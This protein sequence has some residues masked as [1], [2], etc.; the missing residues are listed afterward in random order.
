MITIEN[1]SYF[2][3]SRLCRKTDS[4]IGEPGYRP[5]PAEFSLLKGRT[6]NSNSINIS[7]RREIMTK[8]SVRNK[9]WQV[10]LEEKG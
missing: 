5:Q 7:Q 4:G 1:I 9:R 3:A 2:D 10:N 6:E 8:P